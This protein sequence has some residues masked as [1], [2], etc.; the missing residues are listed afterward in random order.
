M[1]P[2]KL[3]KLF[4]VLAV[5]FFISVST[6]WSQESLDVFHDFGG[7]GDGNRPF[8]GLI[9][10]SEGNLYGTTFMGGPANEGTV[11]MLSPTAGGWK[12]RVLHSFSGQL[13]GAAPF[14][15]VVMDSDGNLYGTTQHGGAYNEGTVFKLAPA[16]DGGWNFSVLYTFRGRNDGG[17]PQSSLVLDAKGNLYG[18]TIGGG[19]PG[20]NNCSNGCGVSF[21]L[22]PSPAGAWTETVLHSFSG[23]ADGSGPDGPLVFDR[24]GNLYG[25]TF[26]G[27]DQTYC[28]HLGCG[29]VYELS[30]SSLGEW[31]QKVIHTFRNRADGD[32]PSGPL[33]FDSLG[34]LF[35]VANGGSEGFCTDGCGIVFEL[36]LSSGGVWEETV[37]HRFNGSDGEGPAM[38]LTLD[39][40]GNIYGATVGGGPGSGG[41]LFELSQDDGGNWTETELHSFLDGNIYGSGPNGRL[42]MDSDG[43]LFGTT[44]SGG[45]EG[46]DGGTVFKV[47][48]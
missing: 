2:T 37:I 35:G 31:K 1:N 45:S 4:I 7:I 9:S 38:G 5:T 48:P 25:T 33:T 23:G 14:D 8:S 12:E 29:V 24:D 20:R 18:T 13:D 32:A 47:T 42:L 16:S 11:Y 43:N 34:D 15:N 27:G 10:D 26:Q 41:L 46:D 22:S 30:P 28:Y 36:A 44:A 19:V 21:R 3:F 17:A 6:A 40:S 39:S